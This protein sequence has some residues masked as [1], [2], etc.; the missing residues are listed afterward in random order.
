KN[1][2]PGA[3]VEGGEV[4]IACEGYDTSDYSACAIHFGAQRGR[5]VSA[6]SSRV[7]AAIPE[8]EVG[9]NGKELRLKSATTDSSVPFKLGVKIAH[10]RPRVATRASDRDDGSIYVTL[11]GQRGQKFPVSIYKISPD[12]TIS[13][14]IPALVNPTGLAFGR[15][16][17][18][19]VTSR[20]DG[21]LYR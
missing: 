19:Y 13:P 5:V 12:D 3:G 15:D 21:A 16:G 6:S 14:F 1:V 20:Y 17:A 2:V 11:S 18:L 4:A 8:Y 10:T 7:I 9:V